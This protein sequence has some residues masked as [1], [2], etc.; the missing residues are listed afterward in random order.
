MLF[1]LN[2]GIFDE[3]DINFIDWLSGFFFFGQ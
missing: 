1:E 2:I 3:I